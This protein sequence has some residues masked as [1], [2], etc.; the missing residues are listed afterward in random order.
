M[1]P[2]GLP[3]SDEFRSWLVRG[4]VDEALE[5]RSRRMFRSGRDL[6]LTAEI[7]ANLNARVRSKVT[8]GIKVK[9]GGPR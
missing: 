8:D 1:F 5:M 3:L 2:H 7:L 4:L 9:Q 6:P